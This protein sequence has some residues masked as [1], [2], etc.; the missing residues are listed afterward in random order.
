[1]NTK[2][3]LIIRFALI[4]IAATGAGTTATAQS[5]APSYISAMAPY[6][7]RQMTGTLAPANG[8]ETMVNVTP[9]SWLTGDPGVI[10]LRGVIDAWSG[11]GKGIGTRLIVHGGGHNDSANNGVYVYD[12]AGTSKPT[13]YSLPFISPVSAVQQASTYADGAPSAA[14]TY[15]GMV[16]V[17]QNNSFYRFGGSKW[18]ST[19]G[20][21]NLAARFNLGSGQWTMLPG[22]PGASSTEPSV[23]YDV[24][25][26]KMLVTMTGQSNAA[27]YRMATNNW[28]SVRNTARE[29][30]E[31]AFAYDPTRSRAIMVGGGSATLYTV[32]WSAETF[33][34][35]ALNASGSTGILSQS[36]LAAFYDAGRDC[37][38]ILAGGSGSSGY[39]N[40]Y[41]MNAGTFNIVQHGLSASMGGF[42]SDYQGSFGRFIFMDQ[43]RAIGIV[44]GSDDAPY[45]IKLPAATNNVAPPNSPSD[46]RAQ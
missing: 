20:W 32:N 24:V 45:V 40:V 28:S 33:S 34:E 16:Y 7:V 22:Y 5:A 35:S 44:T 4:L 43:W 2:T 15:D 46:F 14:H 11:G 41:E 37:Y 27:F 39:S 13:G 1:M 42:N 18:V 12:F 38:W 31:A 23:I 19:G 9:S 3:S 30:H 21:Y 25:S 36:A 17:P 26:G 6:E 10:G 8:M 29:H